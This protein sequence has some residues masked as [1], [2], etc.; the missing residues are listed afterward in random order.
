MSASIG[1]PPFSDDHRTFARRS[2]E[3]AL[4][5][6]V[7]G[8]CLWRWVLDVDGAA[9]LAGAL[10][11]ALT[12]TEIVRRLAWNARVRRAFGSKG[13]RLLGA[14]SNPEHTVRAL[15]ALQSMGT[16]AANDATKEPSGEPEEGGTQPRAA[17]GDSSRE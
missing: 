6:V 9:A 5:A 17:V 8:A 16:E 15:F 4:V 13:R 3:R 12:A 10:F 2:L 7:F 1:R 11:A 14:R